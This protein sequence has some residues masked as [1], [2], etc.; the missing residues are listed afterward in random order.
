MQAAFRN[1][2]P[3]YNPAYDIW[4]VNMMHGEHM[5]QHKETAAFQ[6]HERSRIVQANMK[7]RADTTMESF[8]TQNEGPVP[9]AIIPLCDERV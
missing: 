5:R 4:R 6:L 3:L 9:K 2:I 1:V 7:N 8:S